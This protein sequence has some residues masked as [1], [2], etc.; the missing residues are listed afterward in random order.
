MNTCALYVSAFGCDLL[1][2]HRRTRDVAAGRIAD[3]AGH[4]ADQEDDGVAQVLKMLHLAQ[5]D[6]VAQVQ[7]GRGGVEA[8]LDAKGAT[9]G[10]G[11]LED[12]PADLLRG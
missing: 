2:R 3:Q 6:R 7:V 5:Q 10:S 4:I 9:F 12:G 1:A 8:G 11:G